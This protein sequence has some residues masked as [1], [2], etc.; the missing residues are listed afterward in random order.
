MISSDDLDL[1]LL[2]AEEAFGMYGEL[3]CL[4][5]Y[6]NKTAITDLVILRGGFC[7]DTCTADSDKSLKGRTGFIYTMSNDIDDG[8]VIVVDADGTTYRKYRYNRYGAIRPVLRSIDVFSRISVNRVKGYN[9]TWEVKYGEYPQYAPDASI[10][11][12]LE[13]AYQKGKLKVT[14]RDYT[15]DE[16]KA[17]SYSQEFQPVKY[18]EYEY[19]G[20]KYV[21]VEAN[22]CY[23]GPLSNGVKYKTGDNVWVEVTPITWLIDD[24][25]KLLVS[26]RGLLAGIR[27]HINDE[28]YDGDFKKTDMKRYLDEH[29]SR[30]MFQ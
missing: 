19:D 26:K 25:A 18:K 27:F 13:E 24:M 23:E 10:Q 1:T 7:C 29:M 21:R 15:F 22:L 14:G 9:D 8:N 6:G 5:Q 20:K 16:T 30:D 11:K 2:S 12:R 4:K 3:D 28:V 17:E